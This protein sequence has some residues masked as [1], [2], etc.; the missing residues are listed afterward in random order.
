MTKVNKSFEKKI[1]DRLQK[2]FFTDMLILAAATGTD[3]FKYKRSDLSNTL[4]SEFEF[5]LDK[6]KRNSNEFEIIYPDDFKPNS[7]PVNNK[8]ISESFREYLYSSI[9][10]FLG[11]KWARSYSGISGISI[12]SNGLPIL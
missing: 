8:T 7:L 9:N 11:A 12:L 2:P 10:R 6:P 4:N 3:H 1:D 5:I